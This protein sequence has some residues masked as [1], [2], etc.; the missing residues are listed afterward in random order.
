MYEREYNLDRSFFD[1]APSLEAGPLG[2]PVKRAP[3]KGADV[4]T[5]LSEQLVGC[6]THFYRRRTQPCVGEACSI[7]AEQSPRRWYG[8]LI[9]FDVARREKSLV[10]VPPGVA[11][12]LR[13][14]REQVGNLRGHCMQL[15]RRNSKENG[16][17]VGRFIPGKFASELLPPC[18]DIVP[19]LMRMWHIR[20][21]ADVSALDGELKL[22]ASDIL[23]NHHGKQA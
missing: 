21:M 2:L 4:Y 23:N 9:G 17:V 16:P 7:C 5:I 10:E 14:Y 6:W 3:T 11:L 19:L 18:P 12:A 1:E 20:D 15:S 13:A 8:W 22:H